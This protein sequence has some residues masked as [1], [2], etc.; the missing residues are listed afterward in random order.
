MQWIESDLDS[1]S[2]RFGIGQRR[3]LTVVL[4]PSGDDLLADFGRPLDCLVVWQ[5]NAVVLAA[6]CAPPGRDK[7]RLGSTFSSSAATA[8]RRQ[9]LRVGA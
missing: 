3:R 8:L 4:V 7:G 1:L 5:A 2:R 9:L 6:N